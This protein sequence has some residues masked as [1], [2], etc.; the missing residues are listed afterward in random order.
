VIVAANIAIANNI[1]GLLNLPEPINL[2]LFFTLLI[3]S[4]HLFL[5]RFMLRLSSDK[6]HK[7]E[8]GT[9]YL[10]VTK[11][12][13]FLGMLGLFWSG[14][15]GGSSV[16][17]DGVCYW[18][19]SEKGALVKTTDPDWYKGKRMIDCGRRSPDKIAELDKLVGMRWSIWNNCF[20]VFARWRR[21]WSS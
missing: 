16:Y 5:L 20:T 18:F 4:L 11:P 7:P 13:N 1:I 8:D 2:A 10:I 6:F 9:I 12:H 19:S 21:E 15:G 3:I 17:V 14:L